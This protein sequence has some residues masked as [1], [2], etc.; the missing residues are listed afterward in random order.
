MHKKS[1][2]ITLLSRIFYKEIWDSTTDKY[3]AEE[4][5]LNQLWFTPVTVKL[6]KNTSLKNI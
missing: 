2:L 1:D 5:G 4:P 3:P 6:W